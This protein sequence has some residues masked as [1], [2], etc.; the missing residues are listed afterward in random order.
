MASTK[1]GITASIT[2][3]W[4]LAA[5]HPTHASICGTIAGA[6]TCALSFYLRRRSHQARRT[7]SVIAPLSSIVATTQPSER[8]TSSQEKQTP[9]PSQSSAT[10]EVPGNYTWDPATQIIIIPQL[11][12]KSDKKR[13]TRASTSPPGT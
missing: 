11:A 8:T 5:R 13:F 3:L 4:Q 1:S 2:G 9:P 7:G 10:G 12:E 6:G